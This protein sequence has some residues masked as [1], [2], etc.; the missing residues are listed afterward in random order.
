MEEREKYIRTQEFLV[1]NMLSDFDGRQSRLSEE[2]RKLKVD[3]FFRLSA[4]D[5]Q[6]KQMHENAEILQAKLE[7]LKK[8]S[9]NWSIEKKEFEFIFYFIEGQ[10]EKYISLTKELIKDTSHRIINLESIIMNTSG[11]AHQRIRN[12]SEELKKINQFLIQEINMLKKNTAK[13]KKFKLNSLRISGNL[14]TTVAE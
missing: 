8:M 14:K 12:I 9:L 13:W 6:I 2:K 1:K 10:D 3:E 4:L 5:Q 7:K 11:G